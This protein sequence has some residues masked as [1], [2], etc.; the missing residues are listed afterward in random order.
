MRTI[1]DE[2]D[3]I[4]ARVESD[5]KVLK[6]MAA[7]ARTSN[8]QKNKLIASMDEAGQKLLEA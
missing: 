5:L 8:D 6:N 3:D 2:I 7:A 4:V 1:Y